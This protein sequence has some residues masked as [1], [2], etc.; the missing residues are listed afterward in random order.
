MSVSSFIRRVLK[1]SVRRTRGRMRVSKVSRM[2]SCGIFPCPSCH[3]KYPMSGRSLLETFKCD[4]CGSPVL[5]PSKIDDYLVVEPLGGGG[6]GSV[7][8]CMSLVDKNIYSV[9]LLPRK[10]KANTTCIEALIKEGILH[11]EITGHRN[12]VGFVKAG[13]DGDERFHVSEFLEGERLDTFISTEAPVSQKVAL[14]LI[15][16]LIDAEMHIVSKG[17][18]Y[19]DMKPEN[20]MLQTNGVARLFDFGM[21]VKLKEAANPSGGNRTVD[22]SPHYVPPERMVLQPENESSEIYS[23]GL[24]LFYLLSGRHYFEGKEVNDLAR[25]HVY[26]VRVKST[27]MQIAHCSPIMAKVID[28]MIQ[29]SPKERFQSLGELKDIMLK[30]ARL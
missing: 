23:L 22:G 28:K 17:F 2:V 24:L 20:V 14:D 29:R 6:M 4:R 21:T 11:E 16:Q 3:V 19:R 25:K 9:K 12:I 18:L 26:G 8:M 1:G 30:I 27:S 7:Y 15:I 10:M 5:R 13:N